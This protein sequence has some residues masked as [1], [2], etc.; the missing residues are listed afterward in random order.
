VC[1]NLFYEFHQDKPVRQIS[2][3]ITN[4]QDESSMQLSLFEA[5]KWQK[6]KLGE[7]MDQIRRKY[8]TTAILRA[9]SYTE[10]GTAIH[11]SSL[12]GGHKK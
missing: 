9:V 10:A 3:S 2:L 8:G 6:R 1:Q 11:R 4:L 5:R 7:T 12:L